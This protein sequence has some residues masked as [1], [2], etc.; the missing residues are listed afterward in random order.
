MTSTLNTTYRGWHI[1]VR[2]LP[3]PLVMAMS[4][5]PQGFTATGRAVLHDSLD[6]SGWIDSR[7]QTVTLGE[8][9]YHTSAICT[10][11]LL[12]EIRMLI[13]ALKREPHAALEL[14]A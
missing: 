12:G 6:H 7:P 11:V 10:D 3:Q 5:A 2:C 14:A 1:A 13:D 4:S 8:R 9:M